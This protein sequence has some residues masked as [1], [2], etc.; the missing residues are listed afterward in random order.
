MNYIYIYLNAIMK[1]LSSEDERREDF[2]REFRSSTD[3]K[4]HFF[5]PASVFSAEPW[6][7]RSRGTAWISVKLYNSAVTFISRALP[8]LSVAIWSPADVNESSKIFE[9]SEKK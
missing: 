6:I 1:L 7:H 8:V 2:T 3:T 4:E 5:L 9:K